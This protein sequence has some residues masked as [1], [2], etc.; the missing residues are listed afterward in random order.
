MSSP[1][2]TVTYHLLTMLTCLKDRDDL[3]S[4]ELMFQVAAQNYPLHFKLPDKTHELG[5]GL[6]EL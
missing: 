4:I 2:V 6:E 3:F 5:F 1:A